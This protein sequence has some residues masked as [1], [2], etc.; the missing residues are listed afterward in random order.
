[1]SGSYFLVEVKYFQP[2]KEGILPHPARMVFTNCW[3]YPDSNKIQMV[4][5]TG[6]FPCDSDGL[7]NNFLGYYKAEIVG[8]IDR[9]R[10]T[11]PDRH[12]LMN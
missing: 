3:Y 10:W 9:S 1:M 2:E 11:E 6:T 8:E 4:G 5:S 12:E 7:C